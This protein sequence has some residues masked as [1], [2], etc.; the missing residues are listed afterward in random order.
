M[1]PENARRDAA[2]LTPEDGRASL[3]RSLSLSERFVRALE[4]SAYVRQLAWAG[5][6]RHAGAQNEKAVVG[7]FLR[8][9]YG[10]D[11]AAAFRVA[12]DHTP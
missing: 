2:G 4:L 5:A 12:A 3:L 10:V 1:H 9:L 11:V 6:R 7:R 8:Q